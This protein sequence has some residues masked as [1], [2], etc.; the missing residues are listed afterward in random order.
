MKKIIIILL[1]IMLIITAYGNDI[2]AISNDISDQNKYT[3][4]GG[5]P[6]Q[7]TG[8]SKYGNPTEISQEDLIIE[9]GVLKGVKQDAYKKYWDLAMNHNTPV[10]LDLHNMGITSVGENAVNDLP[11][12]ILKIPEGITNIGD[13][14]FKNNLIVE[15]DFDAEPDS[16]TI[17]EGAFDQVN[18][19]TVLN[20][21]NYT[22]HNLPYYMQL[23]YGRRNP[24]MNNRY[25]PAVIYTELYYKLGKGDI[26]ME[27]P[28]KIK[29]AGKVVANGTVV[30]DSR[31]SNEKYL[32]NIGASWTV[33][34][35]SYMLLSNIDIRYSNINLKGKMAFIK[36]NTMYVDLTKMNSSNR[37]Y[38][39]SAEKGSDVANTAIRNILYNNGEFN[40]VRGFDPYYTANGMSVEIVDKS[41][42]GKDANKIL[43]KIQEL[44]DYD[45][46]GYDSDEFNTGLPENSPFAKPALAS[47]NNYKERHSLLEKKRLDFALVSYPANLHYRF[48]DI[49]TGEQVGEQFVKSYVG[50]NFPGINYP[51]GYKAVFDEYFADN[52][53]IP[54][55]YYGELEYFYIIPVCKKNDTTNEKIV[56]KIEFVNKNGIRIG[57]D[58]LI[59]S[60]K[61]IPNGLPA[62]EANNYHNL[63]Y[64]FENDKEIQSYF[65]SSFLSKIIKN[66][67]YKNIYD[68]LVSESKKELEDYTIEQNGT[69]VLTIDSEMDF[70]NNNSGNNSSNNPI[71]NYHEGSTNIYNNTYINDLGKISLNYDLSDKDIDQGTKYIDGRIK[72]SPVAKDP[73]GRYVY[74]REPYIFGYPDFTVRP[75]GNI[76]R[77]EMAMII[78]RL[79]SY[80]LS[81][82]NP[83]KFKDEKSRKWYTSAINAV[84]KNDIMKGYPDGTF[85][86]NDKVTR[87]EV[88]DICNNLYGNIKIKNQKNIPFNDINDSWA[89]KSIVNMYNLGIINGYPD[90]EFK[91][92]SPVK[93]SEIAKMFNKIYF[94]ELSQKNIRKVGNNF[95]FKN[96]NDNRKEEWFYNDIV[97][98]TNKYLYQLN[99]NIVTTKVDYKD[100]ILN[101]YSSYNYKSDIN[102]LQNVLL[103]F[104]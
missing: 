68:A 60:D 31:T 48:L 58:F 33:F 17:G 51:D 28:I 37:R 32:K 14:A 71:S 93:R 83:T 89:E 67:K 50:L 99:D 34:N 87:A 57:R 65:S 70:S 6:D 69:V 26:Y 38:L 103:Y 94:Y 64:R 84:V 44:A 100:N 79:N 5:N 30:D 92:Y 101:N 77:A 78:G 10:T 46:I 104:E 86:A 72:I 22:D 2:Y 73:K 27:N 97:E 43:E 12:N 11:I 95:N 16:I 85:R 76:T 18:V 41:F 39:L 80:D 59:L 7:F 61:N 21:S 35:N 25:M 56:T 62:D 36:S 82:Y 90:G 66:N 102:V 45:Y 4:R 52:Q 47:M 24:K 74:K 88:A 15:L 98:S 19:E 23:N 29:V 40:S 53:F 96:F 54:R 3:E 81:D 20:G 63:K 13:G 55:Q 75:L 49:G 91:P 1:S 9:N 8:E 42:L